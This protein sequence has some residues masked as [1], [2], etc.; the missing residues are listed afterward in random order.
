MPNKGKITIKS[1][2]N[3]KTLVI[4]PT[5]NEVSN[6]GRRID[7]LEKY[8]PQLDILIVDDNSPD[9]TRDIVTKLQTKYKNLYL[10]NRSGKLGLSSAYT[11]GFNWAIDRDYWTVV[12]M[13][14]DGS[15][16]VK[17]LKEH[18]LPA[19]SYMQV[20]IVDKKPVDNRNTKNSDKY[21]IIGSRYIRAGR[22]KN[23]SLLR[24]LFS[25]CANTFINILFR[26]K[27]Q[28][29]TSG[30]RVYSLDLLKAIL[31]NNKL[32]SYGYFFQV[33]MSLYSIKQ[34]A[35]ILEVPIVFLERESGKS[36]ASKEIVFEALSNIMKIR[37]SFSKL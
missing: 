28:D 8:L 4:L 26:T 35:Q 32:I 13:D 5:Y 37:K 33:E 21:L 31:K 18:L 34:E 19:I 20:N 16:R 9:N 12:Q 17:D 2:S 1:T 10:L 24:K 25:K 6:I 14:A 29:I 30:F 11:D 27:I 3:N 15:H 22:T 36:K 7:E 23:W